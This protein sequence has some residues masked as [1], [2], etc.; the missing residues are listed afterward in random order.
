MGCSQPA[1][2]SRA[3][4]VIDVIIKIFAFIYFL[5]LRL[6][7]TVGR[8]VRILCSFTVITSDNGFS[9]AR[10][11]YFHYCV[12]ILV[13]KYSDLCDAGCYLSVVLRRLTGGFEVKIEPAFDFDVVAFK[14]SV[15]RLRH[16]ILCPFIRPVLR[17][18][19]MSGG[20]RHA[21]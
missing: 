1:K 9:A 10:A 12:F 2:D 6:F 17:H 13:F 19:N 8:C 18:Q 5:L 15:Y 21:R 4:V 3:I 7:C 20:S 14:N 11:G 16:N